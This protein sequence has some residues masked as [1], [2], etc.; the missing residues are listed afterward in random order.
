MSLDKETDGFNPQRIPKKRVDL[1]GCVTGEDLVTAYRIK[2]R[3]TLT[4]RLK[5]AHNRGQLTFNPHRIVYFDP[6]Q[7]QEIFAALGHPYGQSE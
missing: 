2:T 4:K 3:E 7:V 6:W 5:A 1:T